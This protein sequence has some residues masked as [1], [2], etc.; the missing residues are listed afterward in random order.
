[1]QPADGLLGLVVVH[2][3]GALGTKL[4]RI[5]DGILHKAPADFR[6]ATAFNCKTFAAWSDIMPIAAANGSAG[7]NPQR[8]QKREPQD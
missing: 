3:T 2:D 5:A 4:E 6:R 8:N 1:M 7:S